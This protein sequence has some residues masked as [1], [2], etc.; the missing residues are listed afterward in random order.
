MECRRACGRRKLDVF[1]ISASRRTGG[2]PVEREFERVQITL[3]AE[4]ADH[5]LS[6]VGKIRVMPER[7]TTMHVRQMNLDERN[8]DA[9][10]S[11]PDSDTRVRVRGRI[12]Q[13]EIGFFCP[14]GLDAINQSAFMVALER[15]EFYAA[16]AARSASAWS[17]CGRVTR[18]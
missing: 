17:I 5:A 3:P 9:R 11:V 1:G 14:G 8:A 16:S 2:Q 6:L 7:F 4:A 15:R 13:D 18:P 10:E 12:D